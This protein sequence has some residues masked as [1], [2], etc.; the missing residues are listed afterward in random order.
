MIEYIHIQNLVIVESLM[1]NLQ[2]GMTVLTGETGAGKSILIDAL[3]LIMGDRTNSHMVQPDKKRAEITVGF[4][5]QNLPHAQSWLAEQSLDDAHNECII[6]RV[7]NDNGRSRGY[8]NQNP[9]SMQ[10]LQTLGELLVDIHGQHAHHALLK[11]NQQIMLLDAY[12]NHQ[13]YAK[14]IKNLYQLLKH[15]KQHFLDLKQAIIDQQAKQA[16]LTYQIDEL[17]QLNPRQGEYTQLENEYMALANAESMLTASQS[18]SLRLYDGE[19]SVVGEITQCMHELKPFVQ[20]SSTL[21]E[22]IELLETAQIHIQEAVD[23][24]HD[25]SDQL[26]NDPAYLSSVE[27]RLTELREIARKH[28]TEPECLYD[29][30]QTLQTDIQQLNQQDN[31]LSSLEAEI[32]QLAEQYHHAAKQLSDQRHQTALQLEQLI[33]K[34]I[35]QLGMEKGHFK[36]QI[37]TNPEKQAANGIDDIEFTVT[38]NPGQPLLP[39]SKVASG[40]EL[41]RISLAIQVITAH[42]TEIPTLIYD[43]V[44]VGISGGTAEIVGQL[45]RTLGRDRQVVCVTHLPQVAACGHHHIKVSKCSTELT[46]STDMRILDENEKISEIARMSGG[47]ELTD[48]SLAHAKQLLMNA[49]IN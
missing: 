11:K 5:L 16:L 33:T 22:S 35:K 26:N 9:V 43:E 46:T 13:Q 25:F 19:H 34:T 12:G 1:L 10:A 2:N 14:E 24:I 4:S 29:L 28:K 48:Q 44:D 15:K 47:I 3:A 36:I 21:K 31:E 27:K 38:T 39:I 20:Y 42:N 40:G 23:N 30:W 17:E 6:R 37:D 8:I 49:K 41:S 18:C 45:L 7:I 32:D